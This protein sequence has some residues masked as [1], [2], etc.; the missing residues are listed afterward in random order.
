MCLYFSCKQQQFFFLKAYS[1]RGYVSLTNLVTIT[2]KHV[3]PLI[4]ECYLE[5]ERNT[6]KCCI[7]ISALSDVICTFNIIDCYVII[8]FLCV[9]NIVN[10]TQWLSAFYHDFCQSISVFF[11]ISTFKTVQAFLIVTWIKNFPL[12]SYLAYCHP[13]MRKYSSYF[14]MLVRLVPLSIE[15][16]NTENWLIALAHFYL[17]TMEFLAKF[18]HHHSA[19]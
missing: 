5:L 8:T 12:V 6:F 3:R 2:R 1:N 9:S 7:Y 4:T 13:H 11:L 14:S 19:C 15:L 17:V 16:S 18:N 10:L